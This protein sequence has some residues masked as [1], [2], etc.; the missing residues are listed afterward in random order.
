[1][2]HLEI[3]GHSLS[4]VPALLITLGFSIPIAKWDANRHCVTQ[5]P[6]SKICCCGC[7]IHICMNYRDPVG[8]RGWCGHSLKRRGPLSALATS[9][10]GEHPDP[11]LGRLLSFF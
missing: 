4:L 8:Q 9:L 6:A 10:R 5:I 11:C 3:T 7:H 2:L 1:M